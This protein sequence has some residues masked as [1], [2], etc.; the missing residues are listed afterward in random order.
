MRTL[1][2]LAAAGMLAVSA[3]QSHAGTVAYGEAFDTLYRI[4][5][6]SQTA[7]RIGAAGY[8]GNQ[9]IGSIGGLS[10]SSDGELY[11][12][13]G[14]LNALTRVDPASGAAS[15]VGSLGLAGQ[16]DPQRQD[17]LDLGMT[18]GCDG[19]LFLVSAYA[20][21]L[22]KVDPSNAATTLIGSTN[23]TITG[24]VAR[25]NQLFGAGGK[26]DN[27]FYRIDPDTGVTTLIGSYGPAAS[28]WIASVSMSF[29]D[30]GT[31]W[32]VFNYVPPAPGSTS[33]P[34][35]SDLGTIDPETGVVTIVGPITGPDALREVG[36][37]GFAIGPPRCTAGTPL[38]TSAPVG[39]PPWLIVLGLV[40][41]G[42]AGWTLRRHGI[43]H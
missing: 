14:T 8:V 31:L 37:R 34:E 33:V 36:M 39:T 12:I 24:L 17:A 1:A 22:W 11:A 40:M 21:K 6:D 19:S 35:W 42:A 9:L 7:T 23:G 16:G 25:G 4:D 10:Y 41:I 38:V 20:G 26:G 32:A 28:G 27:H 30:A 15:V 2:C 13:S 18:F 43:Q 5:L 3:S 29:D